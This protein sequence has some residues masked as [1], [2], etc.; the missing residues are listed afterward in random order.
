MQ[1]KTITFYLFLVIV[2]GITAY[3]GNYYKEKI[4]KQKY[5]ND[6]EIVKT[7]LLNDSPLYGQ[8]RPKIWIHTKYQ[9]NARKW[10]NF[11][12]RNSTDLNQ[13]YLIL[14]V[15]SIINHCGN[16][17]HICLIDDESFPKLIPEWNIS[18]S[19]LAEPMKSQ[20]RD[21]AMLQLVYHFGGMVVPNSFICSKNLVDL[22][23]KGTLDNKPFFVENH[24]RHC[25]VVKE[26][27]SERFIADIKM[28]GANKHSEVVG[29][30]I[31]F[32]KSNMKTG[33]FSQHNEFE[34]SVQHLLQDALAENQIQ[35]IDGEYIGIKTR[36]KKPILL[37]DLMEDNYLD[38]DTSRI[39]GVLIPSEDI[40]TRPKYQWF[41]ILPEEELLEKRMVISKLLKASMVD[42]IDEYHRS[43]EINSLLAI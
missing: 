31:H 17:F 3:F 10:K 28:M 4:G 43:T 14:T 23:K 18:I 37:E 29:K 32:L 13:P 39:Y 20:A 1:T 6:Y 24:N 38:I 40:L 41:A 7:Y 35:V 22:Y 12:S 9:I 26:K 42:S 34:G 33:H 11:Q 2:I 30:I 21:I 5:E 16:N 25:N 27:R 36:V 19:S 8:N 15:Q